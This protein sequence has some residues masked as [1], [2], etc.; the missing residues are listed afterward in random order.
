M[1]KLK[2]IMAEDKDSQNSER[3]KSLR[4]K[5]IIGVDYNI[6]IAPSGSGTIKNIGEGGA[7]ILFDENI[8]VGTIIKVKFH[9]SRDEGDSLVEAVGKVVWSRKMEDGYDVGI[10]FLT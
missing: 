4:K 8:P 3:R 1:L 2:N 9:L 6:L 10:E 5:C 7:A